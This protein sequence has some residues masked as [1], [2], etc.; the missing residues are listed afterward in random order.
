[1]KQYINL[2]KAISK[3]FKR[4]KKMSKMSKVIES[5]L[6]HKPYKETTSDEKKA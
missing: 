1:M 4:V 2:Y 6:K 3:Q 5:A